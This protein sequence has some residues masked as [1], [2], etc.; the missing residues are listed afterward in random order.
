MG[1]ASRRASG[2]H[3]LVEVLVSLTLFIGVLVAVLVV[4]NLNY[5]LARGRAGAAARQ[6]T[7][8]S[9]HHDLES[10]VRRAGRS[11][12]PH[13]LAI[14]VQTN[15]PPATTIGGPGTP[16]VATGTDVL[17][18]RG[19]L[20]T[21]LFQVSPLAGPAVDDDGVPRPAAIEIRDF[22]PQTGA[23]QDLAEL[24]AAIEAA[25][26][27]PDS[28]LL[29]SALDDSV[30]AV[31]ETDPGGSTVTRSAGR[32]TA[33][34]LAVREAAV[35]EAL[36]PAGS[37]AT[38]LRGAALAG[39]LEEYRFYVRDGFAVPGDDGSRRRPQL[40][41]GR[42]VPGTDRPYADDAANL[43]I[44][45][46]D[47]TLDLQVALGADLDGNGRLDADPAAAG[48]DEW[49]YNEPGEEKVALWA[50]RPAALD[51]V[52]LTTVSRAASPPDG[53]PDGRLEDRLPRPAGE[54]AADPGGY[55]PWRLTS[56]IDL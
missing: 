46:A 8:R 22:S 54:P 31:V 42:F 55:L 38:V 52:R 33:I 10:L 56:L 47:D 16:A 18:L 17:T 7:L 1:G 25:E 43:A 2:G 27:L 24:A 35:R 48:G 32:V 14:A 15:V 20:S 28:L 9:V 53:A 23:P 19:V 40:V 13:G 26:P 4:F 37:L 29:V 36:P 50:G 6:E 49:L 21:P 51:S 45:L 12:L 41:M 3:S 5:R 34:R 30:F 39:V 44:A 11:G